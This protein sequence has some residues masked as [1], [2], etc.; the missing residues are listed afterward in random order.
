MRRQMMLLRQW[1]NNTQGTKKK[2]TLES[3]RCT[4]F[5]HYMPQIWFLMHYGD[6]N[7]CRSILMHK[8]EK[9]STKLTHTFGPPFAKVLKRAE[10]WW[11]NRRTIICLN[12]FSYLDQIERETGTKRTLL[13]I[14]FFD[15]FIVLVCVSGQY[16]H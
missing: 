4:S 7:I 9:A 8:M 11:E 1:T 3:L 13:R 10:I 12:Q 2:E 14:T 15:N 5:I 16:Y 6:G